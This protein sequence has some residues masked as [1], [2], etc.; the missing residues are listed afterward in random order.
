[1]LKMNVETL[2]GI[3]ANFHSLYEQSD[4]GFTLK[5]EGV[6]DVSGLKSA[7]EKEREERKTTKSRL[8]ELEKER[9][10]AEKKILEEQGKYKELTEK[11]RAERLDAQ[12]KFNELQMQVNNA[13]RDA[14]V[15]D[16]ALSMTTDK[17]E[18][19]II[20]RFAT[21]YISADNG[22][23]AFNKSIDDVK[24]ELSRFV[25]SK[26]N[27]S[28]DAGNNRGGGNTKT[29]DRERFMSLSPSEQMDFVKSGGLIK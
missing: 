16:L 11:E 21:D 29:I 7:L 22:E 9:E 18:I 27:G 15:K 4:K 26:A 23:V 13:K 24:A 8:A 6:E 17:D 12:N 5:V 20:S 19:D 14:M 2:E 10:E 28:N 25:K 3:D 1:M